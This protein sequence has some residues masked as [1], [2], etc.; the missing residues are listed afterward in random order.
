[1]PTVWRGVSVGALF[2]L[3]V[4]GERTPL[5][6]CVVEF[7]RSLMSRLVDILSSVAGSSFFYQPASLLDPSLHPITSRPWSKVD[8]PEGVGVWRHRET[9]TDNNNRYGM[10]SHFRAISLL[11]ACVR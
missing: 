3:L 8:C 9:V 5:P 4:V 2:R 10:P 6:A 7:V 1:M 11:N